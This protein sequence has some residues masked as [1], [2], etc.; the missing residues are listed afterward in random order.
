MAES[1]VAGLVH[2]FDPG[3]PLL[4]THRIIVLRSGSPLPNVIVSL[5]RAFT[6]VTDRDGAVTFRL[7]D[8][9]SHSISIT[10]AENGIGREYEIDISDSSGDQTIIEIE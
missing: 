1:I 4:R 6:S 7:L 10:L 9:G 8:N 5:D 2:Y 3:S